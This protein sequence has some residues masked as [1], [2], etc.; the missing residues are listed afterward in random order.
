LYCV[1]HWLQIKEMIMSWYFFI[2]QNIR[3]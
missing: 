1:D 2:L 3:I